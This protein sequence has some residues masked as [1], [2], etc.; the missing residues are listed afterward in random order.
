[1]I[2]KIL[3]S[4]IFNSRQTGQK[5]LSATSHPNIAPR[6]KQLNSDAFIKLSVPAESFCVSKGF[7]DSI[8]DIDIYF[9]KFRVNPFFKKVRV[10]N[11]PEFTQNL[12]ALFK[13]LPGFFKIFTPIKKYK[14]D[15]C[16]HVLTTFQL[17]VKNP[18]FQELSKR[19]QELLEITALLHD[20]GKTVV[21]GSAHV[22]ESAKIAQ[23]ML[24]DKALLNQDKDLIINMIRHHHLC[25]NV[26][27]KKMTPHDYAKLLSE[28]EFKLLKILIDADIK[29]KR[30]PVQYRLDSNIKIFSEQEAIYQS[31]KSQK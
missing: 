16:K 22:E 17:L 20:M 15:L 23:K 14:G 26:D 28:E 2:T 7:K 5:I 18:D 21:A 4:K 10:K 25:E 19:E 31:M 1:M 12:N 11:Q 3:H 30:K 13:D 24:K 9:S 29:S 8:K 27:K 6:L